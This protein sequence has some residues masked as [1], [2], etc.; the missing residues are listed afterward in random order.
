[1]K[2]SRSAALPASFTGMAL[3]TCLATAAM[4][5][6]LFAVPLHCGLCAPVL[7]IPGPAGIDEGHLFSGGGEILRD[8]HA[9][10][11][12]HTDW[13][14]GS[15]TRWHWACESGPHALR[16]VKEAA[17]VG[18]LSAVSLLAASQPS[19]IDIT[20]DGYALV[21]DCDGKTL[22][23]AVRLP[24]REGEVAVHGFSIVRPGT[25]RA[26]KFLS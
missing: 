3:V 10:N 8:C 22:L 9:F 12:C 17:E 25:S 18:A 4:P 15:C 7:G 19:L 16:Q 21:K 20:E 24:H 26:L 6:G 2:T 23:G 1:M 11:A 5:S 13:Q 14:A